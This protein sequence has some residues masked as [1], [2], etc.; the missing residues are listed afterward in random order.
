MEFAPET[1]AVLRAE[2]EE[3]L[4]RYEK[5]RSAVGELRRKAA[6][7]TAEAHT[8]DGLVKVELDA[9]GTMT[10]LHIDS[11]AYRKYPPTV[12]AETILDLVRQATAK[13]T[14]EMGDLMRPVLPDGVT[15]EEVLAGRVG[16]FNRPR[17]R[18]A[19]EMLREILGETD[20][21]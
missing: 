5:L 10:S 15:Y 12:L 11:R 13:A 8:G 1:S 7:T 18:A 21:R 20:W 14:K 2:M 17:P 3:A 19:A 6:A 16:P 9:R 4:E